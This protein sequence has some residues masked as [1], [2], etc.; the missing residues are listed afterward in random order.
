ML[1]FVI[2]NFDIMGIERKCPNCHSWNGENDN[3]INCGYLLSPELI[4]IK[5]EEIR[6]EIRQTKPLPPMDIFLEKW[7]NS[8]FWLLRILYKIIRTIAFIF[9]GI[10]SFFAYLAA[11]PN[12]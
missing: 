9:L 12:G 3:C 6:E 11:S 10:A 5:R 4:E 1:P 8:R 7:K 2:R